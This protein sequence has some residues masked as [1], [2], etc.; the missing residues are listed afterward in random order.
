MP[1][2]SA[3]RASENYPDWRNRKSNWIEGKRNGI[4]RRHFDG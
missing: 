4:A 3:K 2:R 1:D